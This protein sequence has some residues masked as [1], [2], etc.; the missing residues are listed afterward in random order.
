MLPQAE[1]HLTQR[2]TASTYHKL[3]HAT[4]LWRLWKW[5]CLSNFTSINVDKPT[6]VIVIETNIKTT[7]KVD[8]RHRRTEP[9][10]TN[11]PNAKKLEK[12]SGIE[13]RGTEIT[14]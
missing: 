9:H 13:I 14:T 5:G 11:S 6:H 4:K 2:L 7:K 1:I 12:N 3:C 8:L 10:R